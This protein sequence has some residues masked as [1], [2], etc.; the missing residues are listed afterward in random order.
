MPVVVLGVE[1]GNARRMNSH[2]LAA[3]V[4]YLLHGEG[5]DR[6]FAIDN[7]RRLL[8][9]ATDLKRSITEVPMCRG[10]T[11]E[12]ALLGVLHA[13]MLRHLID[14]VRQQSPERLCVG[15]RV[16]DVWVGLRGGRHGGRG[17]D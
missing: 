12:L 1:Q 9:A 8:A 7:A 16:D 17:G 6:G 4:E 10:E 13:E 11:E 3:L 14:D 2:D 15:C 5:A